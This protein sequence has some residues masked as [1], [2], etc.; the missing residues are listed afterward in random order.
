MPSLTLKQR[1]FLIGVYRAH[2]PLLSA[3]EAADNQIWELIKEG[4]LVQTY[5]GIG[6]THLKLTEA[7]FEY[8]KEEI[9]AEQC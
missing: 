2:Y 1:R 9:E 6:G 7:G 3:T 4:I 8:L 5:W